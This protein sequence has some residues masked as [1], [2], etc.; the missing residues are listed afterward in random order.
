MEI[1]QLGDFVY[2]VVVIVLIGY[3]TYVLFNPTKF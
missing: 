1:G 3:L 2:L